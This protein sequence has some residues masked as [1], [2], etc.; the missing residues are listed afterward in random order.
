[1]K[2]LVVSLSFFLC[3]FLYCFSYDQDHYQLFKDLYEL[4]LKDFRNLDLSGL[5]FKKM[6]LSNCIFIRSNLQ[7]SIFDSC[8]LN[9]AS[10]KCSKLQKSSFVRA[11]LVNACFRK[12]NL[13]EANLTGISCNKRTSFIG[14]KMSKIKLSWEFLGY[15]KVV[16]LTNV[17][18]ENIDWFL[19]EVFQEVFFVD[20]GIC[21][22]ACNICFQDYD[23]TSKII[24][25]P[26]QHKI[27]KQCLIKCLLNGFYSCPFC[28]AEFCFGD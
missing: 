19:G 7:D 3:G 1:M 20:D 25:L 17:K 5:N 11:N 15:L 18:F 26:C 16:N 27:C 2:R 10:F 8:E 23:N 24:I 13:N 21:E 4:G 22:R 6:N 12:A 9:N 14:A 28:R